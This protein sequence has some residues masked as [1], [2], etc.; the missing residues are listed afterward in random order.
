MNIPEK[1]QFFYNS[2]IDE[3]VKLKKD[4][5]QINHIEEYNMKKMILSDIWDKILLDIW[6]GLGYHLKTYSLNTKQSYGIDLSEKNIEFAKTNTPKS[7]LF[8]GNFLDFDFWDKKFD[9]IAASLVLHYCSLSEKKTF[10]EKVYRLLN[11]GWIFIWSHK[12]P[13][14]E[15]INFT[16][17]SEDDYLDVWKIQ[18]TNGYYENDKLK[19]KTF[20]WFEMP[21]YHTTMEKFMELI[22]QNNFKIIDYSDC[23]PDPKSRQINQKEFEYY[24]LLPQFMICKLQK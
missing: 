19:Y 1:V 2:I 5:F 17:E 16:T 12:N 11:D 24:S 23:F 7:I 6:C 15:W 13:V 22:I 10:F 20:F 3:Y 21:K 4:H 14:I 8:V 18:K 9:V